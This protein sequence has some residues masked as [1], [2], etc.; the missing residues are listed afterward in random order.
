M[1]TQTTAQ[2]FDELLDGLALIDAY[3]SNDADAM[4]CVA[5]TTDT[6][7][8]VRSTLK[9]LEMVG[10]VVA[11]SPGTSIPDATRALRNRLVREREARLAAA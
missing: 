8:A 5:G 9:V 2:T 10:E 1:T 3:N 4:V 6:V 7:S 11:A